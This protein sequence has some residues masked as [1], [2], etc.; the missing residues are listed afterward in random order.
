MTKLYSYIR[1]SSA[2]QRRGSS[3]ARQST[4]AQE[5]AAL[6]GFDYTE[7]SD[8]GVSAFRGKN[9]LPTSEL[10][11]FIE[12]VEN[13][14]IPSNS[15]LYVENLDRLSREEATKANELFLKLLN[16]GLTIVTGMDNKVYTR[17][18]VNANP[19][20]LMFSIMMFM[21]A[22]EE[23]RTKSKRV[24]G[25]IQVLLE[26]HEQGLP[27]TI[28]SAGNCPWWIDESCSQY[29]KPKKH[30]LY[31]GIAR[32]IVEMFLEGHGSYRIAK[33]LNSNPDIYPAPKGWTKRS[34]QT[35]TV[36][37]L[38]YM[39]R[40][41]ALTG[42][43]TIKVSGISHNLHN[44]YPP[45]C[46]ETEFA[47]LQDSVRNNHI[48]Q[49]SARK[50]ISLLSGMKLLFCA[51]CG[52]AMSF[53]LMDGKIRY[54]CGQARNQANKNCTYWSVAGAPIEQAAFYAAVYA[55][56]DNEIKAHANTD[57]E[58]LQMHL[59][60]LRL[61]Y[62]SVQSQLANTA[63]AIR[64][65]NGPLPVLVQSLQDL[66]AEKEGLLLELEQAEHQ[67]LLAQND[68]VSER[69]TD[70]L[71]QFRPEV[72]QDVTH[73]ARER[74]RE[75]FRKNLLRISVYKR[76]NKSIIIIFSMPGN[77]FYIVNGVLRSTHGINEK[78]VGIYKGH[79]DENGLPCELLEESH[80]QYA[81]FKS[82]L[83]R[84]DSAMEKVISDLNLPP[85][86]PKD[87]FAQR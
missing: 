5:Y 1:W 19:M 47:Q 29:E 35:W 76:E 24:T 31:F 80:D 9:M 69:I 32:F 67:L 16:L 84:G 86:N 38:E 77:Y 78:A 50:R 46:T 40:S 42:D 4:K 70:I 14:I 63:K 79:L 56:F 49:S 12:A 41:K 44:Y 30:E 37:K 61:R 21:R 82:L 58:S 10:G 6:N 17:D 11:K 85:Y 7:I 22:N 20:D 48:S 57:K 34:E 54:C 28:K 71:E 60:G 8:D 53:Y 72:W 23:S 66:D 27:V 3:K 26:R 64:M 45:V 83:Y 36:R 39:R 73:P 74:I 81:T 13:K 75:I 51:N 33:L 43:Y 25:N 68:D 52:G 15:C 65:A 55:V 2:R 18:S 59:D 87:F 62:E